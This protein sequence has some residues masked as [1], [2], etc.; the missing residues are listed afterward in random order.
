MNFSATP[1]GLRDQALSLTL[2]E[3]RPEVEARRVLLL[4]SQGEYAARLGALEARLLQVSFQL[5]SFSAFRL[6]SFAVPLGQPER[7]QSMGKRCRE[8]DSSSSNL[9]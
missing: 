2:Q 8:S 4:R 9:P 6:F 1:A 3:E 5:F 7:C